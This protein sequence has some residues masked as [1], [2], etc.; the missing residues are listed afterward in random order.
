MCQLRLDLIEL[1]TFRQGARCAKWLAKKIANTMIPRRAADKSLPFQQQKDG[2]AEWF[3]EMSSSFIDR[4]EIWI[5]PKMSWDERDL[6]DCRQMAVN[7]VTEANEHRRKNN[8]AWMVNDITAMCSTI[9]SRK[10]ANAIKN[11]N[12]QKN[13]ANLNSLSFVA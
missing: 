6:Y 5:R 10:I 11:S 4:V 12:C 1:N 2:S 9:A 3:D 13:S 7:I 8:L